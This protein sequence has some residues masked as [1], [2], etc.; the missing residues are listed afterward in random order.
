[1][2]P[3]TE[4]SNIMDFRVPNYNADKTLQDCVKSAI[5]HYF[6][7]LDG[8]DTSGLYSLVLSEV[9]KPLLQA[10]LKE[11]QGNQSRAA[12]ILGISRSTLRKKLTQYDL[13]DS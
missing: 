8:H 6:E 4:T 9:E 12:K 5:K 7:H 2:I 11:T 10:V 3:N 1:M 13:A